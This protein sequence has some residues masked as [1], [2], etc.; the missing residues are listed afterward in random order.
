VV[1]V[2]AGLLAFYFLCTGNL[3]A[4]FKIF[5]QALYYIFNVMIVV[6]I[7]IH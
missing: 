1:D 7:F 5:I 3:W 4:F 2:Q 6:K